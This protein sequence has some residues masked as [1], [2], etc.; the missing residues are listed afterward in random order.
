MKHLKEHNT[1]TLIME[2]DL[3]AQNALSIL[4]SWKK[5]LHSQPLPKEIIL[6]FA[7][8]K[9][10]DTQ[11]ISL[12]IGLIK[13]CLKENTAFKFRSCNADTQKI[14]SIINLDRFKNVQK[15]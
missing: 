5:C 3:T 6:D 12:I 4:A 7:C 9:Q 14:L 8:V 15:A 13:E 11:G 1:L 10:I 2:E